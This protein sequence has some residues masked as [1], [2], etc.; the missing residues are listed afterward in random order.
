MNIRRNRRKSVLLSATRKI[1][2]FIVLK[3]WPY[4]VF[5]MIESSMPIFIIA[6]KMST[7]NCVSSRTAGLRTTKDTSST[8]QR[9]EC[10]IYLNGKQKALLGIWHD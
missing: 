10:A 3:T 8:K 6:D 5:G 2:I 9:K 1:Q 4:W 7:S